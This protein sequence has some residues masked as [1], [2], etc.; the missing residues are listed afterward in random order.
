MNFG[1]S[2]MKEFV[3]VHP[4]YLVQISDN[5]TTE[6][7]HTHFF[8]EKSVQ[9]PFLVRISANGSVQ[10]L[11]VSRPFGE[12]GVA[13]AAWTENIYV[14]P[15][16]SVNSPARTPD[17]DPINLRAVARHVHDNLINANHV[18]RIQT[19]KRETIARCLSDNCEEVLC[20]DDCL[21][22]DWSD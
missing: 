1:L 17:D 20:N 7:F 13:T 22:S 3:R 9:I 12:T 10:W 4:F 14:N 18:E 11:D 15:W 21:D 19:L 2:L 5:F 16:L 6:T 8:N